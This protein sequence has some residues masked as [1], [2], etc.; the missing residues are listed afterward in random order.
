M[1]GMH[2][3]EDDRVDRAWTDAGSGEIPCKP[4]KRRAEQVRRA[5]IDKDEHVAGIDQ[6]LI[7]R[8]WNRILRHEARIEELGGSRGIA[9][10]NLGFERQPA[11]IEHGDLEGTDFEAID[12]GRLRTGKRRLCQGRSRE[13][14]GKRGKT[15]GA[16]GELHISASM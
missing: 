15:E 7:D 4:P 6:P 13:S 16:A 2:V 12:A 9:R 3:G 5:G 10:E 1:V 8:C 11:V 14:A